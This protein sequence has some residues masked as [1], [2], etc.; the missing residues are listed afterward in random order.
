MNE[1]EQKARLL[2][3]IR[4]AYVVLKP[5]LHGGMMGC[6]EWI[7]LAK[8]RG[9]GSWITSA[10][11]SNVGLNAIAHLCAEEYGPHIVMPQGLGT[12]MLYTDN[13]EM[14]LKIIGDRLWF[15]RNS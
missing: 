8:D 6:R 5:S 1:L 13:V 4:P 14:P 2:D 11:E 9:V 15:L 10:L 12:G 7:R 3:T